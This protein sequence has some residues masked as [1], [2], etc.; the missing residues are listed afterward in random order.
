MAQDRILNPIAGTFGDDEK[1]L[2]YECIHCGFC[3][4]SCPTYAIN[5]KE[6]DSPRGRLYLMETAMHGRIDLSLPFF[7]HMNL[8]LECLACETACPSGVEFGHLMEKTRATV[9]QWQPKGRISRWM[10]TLLLKKVI[11]SSGVLSTL[12]GLIWIYERSGIQWLVRRTPFRFLLPKRIRIL[13]M[14]IPPV[15]LKSFNSGREQIFHT[16]KEKRGKVALFTGCIMDQLFPD[17]H[18]S[19]VRLLLWHGYDVV[20]PNDQTCCG[21]L[22]IHV[23]EN[24]TAARLAEANV[25]VFN[26]RDCDA[27][28]VNAAG[29]GAH[30]KR[31]DRI[32]PS[33]GSSRFAAR[34]KDITE[35]LAGID[36][37]QP[38]SPLNLRVV[39][40]EPCHLLHAQGISTEPRMLIQTVPG[41]SLIPLKE[42]D[43][44]CGSAGSYAVS[45][46]DMSLE[47]LKRK[48]DFIVSADPD[49]VITANPGCQIQ[50][51][52]G[53]RQRNIDLEVIH[54][55]SLLDRAYRNEPGYG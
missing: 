40:D 30:M 7:E 6:M 14:S 32:C 49:A 47:V 3:L 27:V 35:F 1:H 45:Q 48:I 29:C 18:L 2:L 4:P 37:E 28:I 22:Q 23:G 9:A 31:Y 11:P 51:Q 33:G 54:V 26:D 15:P 24:E 50:L 13:E 17:V 55:A 44:C 8:C 34:V 10:S 36:L 52:W 42:S 43:R 19:T 5:G 25:S 38:A 39:Y 21:A 53:F 16:K 41:I 12:T 20:V 46:M